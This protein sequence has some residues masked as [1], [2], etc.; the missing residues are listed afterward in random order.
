[1]SDKVYYSGPICKRGHEEGRLKSNG[2]CVGCD[3]EWQ[4]R[5]RSQKRE[6]YNERE[7]NRYKRDKSRIRKRQAGYYIENREERL[8][9]QRTAKTDD[10]TKR[11]LSNA[12]QRSKLKGLEFSITSGDLILVSFCPI[13]GIELNYTNKQAL[14]NSPS[15]DR[16]DNTK[17]YTKGNV[18][19][20]SFRANTLKSS[21][22]LEEFEKIVKWFNNIKR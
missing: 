5:N 4:Q 19:I 15:I 12:K 18:H 21:G 9:K 10:P 3:R 14:D 1:M 11:M 22:T 8:K 2:N 13:L 7:R 16:I 20:I 6:Q 17:G